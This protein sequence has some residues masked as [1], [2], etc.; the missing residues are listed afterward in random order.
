MNI[1][2]FLSAALLLIGAAQVAASPVLINLV[3]DGKGGQSASFSITH[4]T[5]GEFTDQ[6]L[7]VSPGLKMVNGQLKTIGYAANNDIDFIDANLNGFSFTFTK[8]STQAFFE[9]KE[10]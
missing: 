8:L 3:S 10:T 9:Y 2:A 4:T 7:F 5:V 6:F 1:K